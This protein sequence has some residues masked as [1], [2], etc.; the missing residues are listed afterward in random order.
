[1]THTT[2]THPDPVRATAALHD[3]ARLAALRR[4]GLLDAPRQDAFDRLTRLA[5][6]AIGAPVSLVSLVDEGR[7]FFTSALGLAEPVATARQTPLSHSLCRLVLGGEELVVADSREHPLVRDNP[8]ITDFGVASYAGIPI[9]L[10]GGETLGSL[11]VI[12]DVPREWTGDEL[13]ILRDLAAAAVTEA[14]L[15]LALIEAHARAR[16]DP[17]TGLLNHGAFHERLRD[18]L[19]G[20]PD[21]GRELA[22]I[23]LDIDFFK[24]VNDRF[25]H[26]AGDAALIE[27]A[28]RID[29]RTR[30]GDV[31]A[32][33]GGEEFAWILPGTSRADAVAAAERARRAVAATPIEGI[34]TLTISAGVVDRHDAGDARR[35]YARADAA[36]YAAKAGGRNR[37]VAGDEPTATAAEPVARPREEA[38]EHTPPGTREHAAVTRLV[39]ALVS[40]EGDVT[41]AARAVAEQ[42]AWLARGTGA[43]VMGHGAPLATWGDAAPHRPS[44]PLV[45]PVL[46][47]DGVWGAIEVH[48]GPRPGDGPAPPRAALETLASLFALAVANDEGRVRLTE[49]A[50]RDHLTGLPHHR[51]FQERLAEE[52]ARAR[53]HERRL[54]LVVADLDNFSHVNHDHGHEAGDRVL[55]EV[56]RRMSA[57]ARPGDTV[58][59]LGGGQ[60]A[61]V[62]PECDELTAWE[63]AEHLR[64]AIAGEPF[65]DVGHVT[66]SSGVCDLA[67]AEDAEQLHQRAGGALYWAKRHGRNSVFLYAPDVIDA[68]TAEERIERLER[69]QAL[70]GVRMIARVVDAKDPATRR[71]S[72][73]VAGLAVRLA[74]VMG[75]APARV[76]LLHEAGLVHD[77]G[78]IGVPDAIL[79]SA[80]R[81]TPGEFAVIREHAA[82]G[83]KIV[84][85][86]LDTEQTAWV[87]SHHERH[88]GGGYPDGI[89]G[90]AIP[91]GARILA[92]AD[93]WDVMTVARH[94][95]A[96]MTVADALAECRRESGLQFAPAVVAALE[97]LLAVAPSGLPGV[98]VA[99]GA[100]ADGPPTR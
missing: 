44:H 78:K 36:L 80:G 92:L 50:D 89:A 63:A 52:V 21:D 5:A 6:D 60:F 86:V 58:A 83:A 7:Q 75:W 61:W 96:P 79:F 46:T 87:R 35:L 25:G 90:D 70:A 19:D 24:S 34:G 57:A 68:L 12:D 9:T 28:R 88:D 29:D 45:V 65:P 17:M 67:S 56:A 76:A 98:P 1:M 40:S 8:S 91:E 26:L 66:I 15:R 49:M 37:V 3:P 81:L 20:A 47:G 14:E 16:C 11:C 55:I 43:T 84:A 2:D 30:A 77:V 31:L 64:V 13:A 53:R 100:G 54:A 41:A 51:A 33:V 59:R 62:L 27:V 39:A 99:A 85:E 93:S 4:T 95:S 23:L 82:L 10:T 94:Y 72:E 18:E 48:G 71:H 74:T 73:R 22:L 97:D 38:D 32:R 42:A 69:Q